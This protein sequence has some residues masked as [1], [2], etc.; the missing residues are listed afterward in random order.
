MLIL[1]RSEF[2]FLKGLPESIAVPYLAELLSD[3]TS[4]RRS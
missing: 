2:I 1:L 3:Y 4:E